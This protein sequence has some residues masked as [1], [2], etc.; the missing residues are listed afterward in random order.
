MVSIICPFAAHCTCQLGDVGM[1][2]FAYRSQTCLDSL[3]AHIYSLRVC[4]CLWL[5]ETICMLMYINLNV[6][7]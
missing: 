4:V 5:C 2:G 3:M 6:S 1:R 7:M